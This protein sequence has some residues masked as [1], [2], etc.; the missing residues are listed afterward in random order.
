VRVWASIVARFSLTCWDVEREWS[1]AAPRS[2]VD[3]A[4][5]LACI[6]PLLARKTLHRRGFW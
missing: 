2:H 3:L 4:T 1:M 6:A 5:A